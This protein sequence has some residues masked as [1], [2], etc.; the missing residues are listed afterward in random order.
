L[1]MDTTFLLRASLHVM[2]EM[3]C[4]LRTAGFNLDDLACVAMIEKTQSPCAGLP[5]CPPKGHGKHHKVFSC[6]DV[7]MEV[8][9]TTVLIPCVF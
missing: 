3:A 6:G 9:S 7:I 8:S 5:T 1:S 4:R 2:K